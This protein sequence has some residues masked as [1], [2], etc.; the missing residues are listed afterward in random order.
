MCSSGREHQRFAR[1]PPRLAGTPATQVIVAPTNC[2]VRGVGCEGADW[3]RCCFCVAYY[4]PAAL[5]PPASIVCVCSSWRGGIRVMIV[6]QVC[7][8]FV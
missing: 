1:P 5:R 6:H 3:T 7:C 8:A 2:R 4:P